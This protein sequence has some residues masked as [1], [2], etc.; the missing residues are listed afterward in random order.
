MAVFVLDCRKKTAHAVLGKASRRVWV[1]M[2]KDS[3][4]KKGG[5]GTGRLIA[6]ALSLPGLN[7]G[8]SRA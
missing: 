2:D 8:V 6:V 3:N 4:L 5:A 7:A 1:F